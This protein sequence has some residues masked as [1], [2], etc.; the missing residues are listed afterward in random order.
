MMMRIA[1]LETASPNQEAGGAERFQQGLADALINAGVSVTPIPVVT[2]AGDYASVLRSYLKFYDL[3]LSS[4]DG[5]ISTK[6]PAYLAR[7]PNHVVYLQHTM[8]V[9]Y[10]MFESE[11]GTPTSED[12]RQ[13]DQI[14]ELDSLALAPERIK[15][16]FTISHEVSERLFAFNRLRSEVLY[17][18]TTLSGFY[19]RNQKYLFL[20]GRLHRWKRVELAI[21]AMRYVDTDV[22]LV[23]SGTGEDEAS[24]RSLAHGIERVRFLGRIS[25]AQ[26]IDLYADA[27]AVVFVPLREDFGL[28]TLEAFHSAK[29]LITCADSGEPA[30]IVRHEETGFICPP[31]PQALASCFDQLARAPALAQKMG[32]RGKSSV[33]TMTWQHAAAALVAAL[34]EP[35]KQPTRDHHRRSELVAEPSSQAFGS[36]AVFDMQPIDPPTGGGRLRLLGL[37]HGLGYPVCYVGTYD[38]PGEP[39]RDHMLSPTLR[40]IDVPLTAEHHAA[41][42]A[43]SRDLSGKPVID[44]AFPTQSSHSPAYQAEAL[45]RLAQAEIAIFSHPW[46]YPQLA[47]HIDPQRHLR[48]YDAH[49]VEAIL[50]YQLLGNEGESG[51]ALARQVAQVEAAICKDSDTI[52]ACSHEDRERFHR[53][54]DISYSKI[55]VVPNGVFTADIKPATN[56]ER[57]HAR[58]EFRLS[59]DQ[60]LAIFLGSSYAPNREAVDFI[61]ESLAPRLPNIT[62]LIVGGVGA[63]LEGRANLP[64]NVKITG[65]VSEEMKRSAL[66]A[67]DLALNTMF[68]GSGTNIK[69][70]EY[71]A[72][73]LPIISTPTGARGLRAAMPQPFLRVQPADIVNAISNLCASA[74][75]RRKLAESARNEAV[76]AYSWERISADVGKLL[77][78]L[79]MNL[80]RRPF[81][82][83]LI[84]TY[85]RHVQLERLIGRLGQQK[86]LDFEVIVVDQSP[87]PWSGSAAVDLSGFMYYHTDVV[88]A[89]DARNKAAFFAS[90]E[91]LAFVDDD[92]LPEH[93]WLDNARPYFSNGAVVGLEGL[94][95][96]EKQEDARYRSVS[97]QTFH[98]LGFMT[99]NFFI[100]RDTFYALDGFDVAFDRPHFREDTDLGWRA[101]EHGDIPFAKDVKVFHP[102]QARTV[103]RESAA[104][105]DT[106]FEKDALLWKKHPERYRQLFLAEAHWMKTPG[107]KQHFLRG[108]EKYGVQLD[109]FFSSYLGMTG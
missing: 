22:E 20:P 83:V 80:N 34:E 4:Y 92:C 96:S 109:P 9:F 18:A 29:P 39:Y 16:L 6:A 94:I 11:R 85:Q 101:L 40:E 86:E 36:I 31:E 17:Q 93:S 54:Y 12:R 5:V 103:E 46:I 56:A 33:E 13:R 78:R 19:A 47:E 15:R 23:I 88:G 66:A 55:R 2:D 68:S 45:A 28:V 58:A 51:L 91:I 7:H 89:V 70:L 1:L 8:R 50:R 76:A 38:W 43:L 62:F 41:A 59:A 53:L 100:R 71:M 63:D 87:S 104:Y 61:L 105:R 35:V 26:L 64:E 49:N 24:L 75:A 10:D 99:A 97:N 90:G 73:G 25:D 21:E 48:I 60:T 67:A 37:Y 57:R 14:L 98:G 81:F 65:H 44:V 3:D 69:M 107:F 27:L 77:P 42:A 79:Y 32:Q 102:A 30:R 52:F 82:S 106:F 72:A 84:P 95:E 108:H 74:D